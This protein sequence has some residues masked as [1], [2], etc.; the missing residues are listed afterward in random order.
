MIIVWN[1]TLPFNK[2]FFK[3]KGFACYNVH[4]N[5][6]NLIVFNTYS[7]FIHHSGK[8]G[9]NFQG[10]FVINDGL[11]PNLTLCCEINGHINDTII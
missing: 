8:L 3:C 7:N 2:F 5:Y 9:I 4:K 10:H 1:V 6:H 11:C